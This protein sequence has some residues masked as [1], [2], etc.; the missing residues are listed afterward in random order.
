MSFGSTVQKD[1]DEGKGKGKGQRHGMLYI[2]M[3]S[4][5]A[6]IAY[7]YGVLGMWY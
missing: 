4:T 1:E 7:M 3:Y 6:C 2:V 5:C